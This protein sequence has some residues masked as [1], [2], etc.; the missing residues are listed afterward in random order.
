MEKLFLG[1]DITVC[2]LNVEWFTV[3]DFIADKI[4]KGMGI[5]APGDVSETNDGVL[6]K[7]VLN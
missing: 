5:G 1:N 3:L 6:P 4:D 2:I 7:C